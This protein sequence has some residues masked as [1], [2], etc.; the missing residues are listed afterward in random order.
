MEYTLGEKETELKGFGLP[1]AQQEM[2]HIDIRPSLQDYGM[3]VG[4][5]DSFGRWLRSKIKARDDG[6][7][8]LNKVNDIT[9][10]VLWVHSNSL[11][12]YKKP[13]P[14]MD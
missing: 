6:F 2:V 12:R 13:P 10:K 5:D 9:G 1:A 14:R 7:A 3:S 8:G 4:S 11:T